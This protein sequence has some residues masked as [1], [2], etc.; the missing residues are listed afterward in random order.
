MKTAFAILII[1]LIVGAV[2]ALIIG[3]I[4]K[5]NDHV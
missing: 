4:L 3:P 1:W 2:I 5:E